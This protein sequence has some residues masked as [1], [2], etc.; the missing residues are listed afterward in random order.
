MMEAYVGMDYE[1]GLN[2]LKD[3]VEKGAVQSKLEFKGESTFPGTKYIG[4][5][6]TCSTD[7]INKAMMENFEKITDWLIVNNLR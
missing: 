1:R 2:L 3:Y 5:K 7:E 6:T 4:A